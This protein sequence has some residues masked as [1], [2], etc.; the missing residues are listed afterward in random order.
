MNENLGGILAKDRI[1]KASKAL[2]EEEEQKQEAEK[3]TQE[4]GVEQDGQH[5]ADER[6]Q[7]QKARGSSTYFSTQDADEESASRHRK[8]RGRFKQRG[9][10]VSRLDEEVAIPKHSRVSQAQPSGKGKE[11]EKAGEVQKT[12][13]AAKRVDVFIPTVISVG[14]LAKLL[15]VTLGASE[16]S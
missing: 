13:N 12:A 7:G 9:S 10:L 8:E 2:V 15:N 3:G 11:K 4:E 16:R 1:Q 5:V 6:R 14:N